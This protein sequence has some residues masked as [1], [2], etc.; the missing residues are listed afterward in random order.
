VA[1]VI[2]MMCSPVTLRAQE[3]YPDHSDLSFYADESGQRHA[4]QNEADWLKRRRDILAGLE[5]AMGPLPSRNHLPGLEI[6]VLDR[7]N[8]KGYRR[9]TITFTPEKG[10]RLSADLYL[11]EPLPEGEKRPAILALH[12]TGPLG[13]RIVAGEAGKPNRQ[14]AVELA[15]RG[16]VVLAPDYPS[17][18]DYQYDFNADQYASG[19][20]K[21][22]FNHMRCVDLLSTLPMVDSDRIGAIGHSLGGHNAMFLGVFDPRVKVIISSCGWCPF[23]DYYGGKIAGWTSDRYMPRLRDDYGLDPDRVPFDFYEVVAA[24]A[25]RHFFSC[26]PLHDANFDVNGVRKAI[27][28]AREVYALFQATDH[29]QVRYPDCEHDFPTETREEVYQFLDRVL[30]HAP[31][32]VSPEN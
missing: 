1:I 23:H 11:P 16:Y 21:G 27:P 2:S 4:V 8:G 32:L 26:S 31:S 7:K 19:T 12:P 24:L 3:R 17:F 6:E 29:L 15:Q 10:D 30:N 9:E 28:R 5:Q 22:I 14:Y 13:K 25:P 18:G 20:M